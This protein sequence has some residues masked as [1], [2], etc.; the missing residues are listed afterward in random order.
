[1]QYFKYRKWEFKVHMIALSFFFSVL[2]SILSL[3]P[4]KHQT[5]HFKVP[6]LWLPLFQVPI[7]TLIYLVQSTKPLSIKFDATRG[8]GREILEW[9]YHKVM[10]S[11]DL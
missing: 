8:E 4:L 5:S 6:H 3:F 1:M 2:P 10:G 11:I 7:P 9:P